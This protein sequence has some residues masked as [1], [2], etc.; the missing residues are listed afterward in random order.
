M[1][2]LYLLAS[3]CKALLG[4]KCQPG[5]IPC[6]PVGTAT[7]LAGLKAFS[8]MCESCSRWPPQDMVLFHLCYF[9]SPFFSWFWWQ[10]P[11]NSTFHCEVIISG[12]KDFKSHH[13]S[14]LAPFPLCYLHHRLAFPVISYYT[15]SESTSTQ[16]FS[17]QLYM[18]FF[19]FISSGH[20]SS[21]QELF[22]SVQR[23]SSSVPQHLL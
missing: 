17:L 7:R 20:S 16:P 8:T 14:F 10:H 15:S 13:S 21:S 1:W 9:P 22:I 6:R 3:Q 11:G 2:P 12:S 18:L 23:L 19:F 4:H 5:V